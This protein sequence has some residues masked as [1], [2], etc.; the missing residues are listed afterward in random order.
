[1][2]FYIEMKDN[3]LISVSISTVMLLASTISLYS[4]S[5][6]TGPETVRKKNHKDEY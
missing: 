6:S 4:G 3:L 2:I 5:A 1:M